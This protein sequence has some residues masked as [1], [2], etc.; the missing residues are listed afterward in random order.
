MLKLFIIHTY[1]LYNGNPIKTGMINLYECQN[2]YIQT[3]EQST[4]KNLIVDYISLWKVLKLICDCSLCKSLISA[5]FVW[6]KVLDPERYSLHTNSV[7][8]VGS[9]NEPQ[10]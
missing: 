2:K 6:V 8:E 10:H 7:T 1:I 3:G 5:K 9:K 4:V